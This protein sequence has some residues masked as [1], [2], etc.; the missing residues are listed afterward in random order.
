MTQDLQSLEHIDNEKDVA[1]DI[2]ID[3]MKKIFSPNDLEDPEELF[4]ESR[5]ELKSNKN[6]WDTS[7]YNKSADF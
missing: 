2:L 3:T 5:E 4:N 6:D 7:S 1:T